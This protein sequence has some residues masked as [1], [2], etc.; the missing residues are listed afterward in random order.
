MP[1]ILTTKIAASV[2]IVSVCACLAAL[3]STNVN[4]YY[5]SFC[6]GFCGLLAVHE[7]ADSAP[8]DYTKNP[9]TQEEIALAKATEKKSIVDTLV[10]H[11]E[12]EA[13]EY[14]DC[15]PCPVPILITQLKVLEPSQ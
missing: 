12:S 11:L 15:D 4:V 5:L 9:I 8:R 1:S 10:N 2:V 13:H 14:K 3:I 7:T 6:L